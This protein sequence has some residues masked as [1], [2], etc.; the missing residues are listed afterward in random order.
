M[1]ERT[2]EEIKEFFG[3]AEE[4][5]IYFN[6]SK[7]DIKK[8]KETNVYNRTITYAPMVLILGH[9]SMQQ[10]FLQTQIKIKTN[11]Q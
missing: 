9:L 1:I 8:S 4:D 7:F 2:D 11:E 6:L 5:N 10:H 3:I